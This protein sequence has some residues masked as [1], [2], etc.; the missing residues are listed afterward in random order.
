MKKIITTLFISVSVGAY[1]QVPAYVSTDSLKGFWNLN[2]DGT[3]ETD[4]AT[5][6]VDGAPYATDRFGNTGGAAEFSGL[7]ADMHMGY[8]YNSELPFNSSARTISSWIRTGSFPTDFHNFIFSY[9]SASTDIATSSDACGLFITNDGNYLGFWSGWNDV[10]LAYTFT[11]NTWYHL[12]VTI[13]EAGN[14][15]CFV[16]GVSIGTA[17]LTEPLSTVANGNYFNIG[18]S[19]HQNPSAGYEGW[20]E[21]RLD[22]LAIWNRALSACEIQKLS[23]DYTMSIAQTGN[24]LSASQS[25]GLYQWLTCSGGTYSVIGSATSQTYNPTSA[26]NYALAYSDGYCSDTTACFN[27][28]FTELDLNEETDFAVY[29]NPANDQITITSDLQEQFI[30]TNVLGEMVTR[31]SISGQETISISEWPAGI[32]LLQNESGSVTKIIKL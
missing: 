28:A 13:D 26:G 12:A 27:F 20:L 10:T 32:Y 8:G 14:V 11:S 1:L 17:I 19:T 30:V 6:T 5:T 29:P 25:V 15:E 21:G 23:D 22:E 7:L 24:T 2:G 16:D 3:D 4:N 31:V 18:R 9:G